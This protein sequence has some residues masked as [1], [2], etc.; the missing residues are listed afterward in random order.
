M[1]AAAEEA[2]ADFPLDGLVVVKEA[3]GR[4]PRRLPVVEAGHPVPDWRGEE[5]AGRILELASSARAR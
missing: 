1:A 3:R 5:A 4:L 2:L